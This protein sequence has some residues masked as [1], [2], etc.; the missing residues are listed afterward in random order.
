MNPLDSSAKMNP[1]RLSVE[2]PIPTFSIFLDQTSLGIKLVGKTFHISNIQTQIP[3]NHDGINSGC[4]LRGRWSSKRMERGKKKNRIYEKRE[5]CYQWQRS[6]RPN[7]SST[8]GGGERER[9]KPTSSMAFQGKQ[10]LLCPIRIGNIVADRTAKGE[11]IFFFFFKKE[12][13]NQKQH[14]RFAEAFLLQKILK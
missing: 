5:K 3:R 12:I 10:Q 2:N 11:L 1:F 8:I 9:N 14:F 6:S 4:G 7:Q 13:K